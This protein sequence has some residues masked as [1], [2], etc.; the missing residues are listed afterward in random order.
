MIG[1]ANS[2]RTSQ[3]LAQVVTRVEGRGWAAGG[4][5]LGLGGNGRIGWELCW[6]GEGGEEEEQQQEAKAWSF[7]E[8]G[9]LGWRLAVGGD[10]A[11]LRTD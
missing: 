3:Q 10:W 2:G 9:G 6:K 5:A 4:G 8:L 7:S 1:V 11:S